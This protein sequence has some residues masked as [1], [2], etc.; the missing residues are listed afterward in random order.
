MINL[1][2]DAF[3]KWEDAS[4]QCKNVGLYVFAMLLPKAASQATTKQW[5]YL[6]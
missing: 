4:Y 5:N 2:T 3:K 6:I 1:V